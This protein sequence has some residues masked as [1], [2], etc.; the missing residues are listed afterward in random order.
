[1]YITL[2]GKC[3]IDGNE[4]G[5]GKLQLTFYSSLKETTLTFRGNVDPDM[6]EVVFSICVATNELKR[7]IKCATS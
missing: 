4:R 5:F 1:M 3:H 2:S 6:P 7:A